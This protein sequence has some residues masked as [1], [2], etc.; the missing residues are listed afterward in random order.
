MAKWD[1]E[2]YDRWKT[3]DP[4]EDDGPEFFGDCPVCGE[5]T[6]NGHECGGCEDCTIKK[7]CSY[8]PDPCDECARVCDCCGET[9]GDKY[10]E[11]VDECGAGDAMKVCAVCLSEADEGWFV[12]AKAGGGA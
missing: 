4:R 5:E 1:G 11:V 6:K 9:C 8:Y 2:A 7:P 12:E 3:S 10:T